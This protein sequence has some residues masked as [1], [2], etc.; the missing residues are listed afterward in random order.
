MSFLGGI[1]MQA[2]LGSGQ[3]QRCSASCR[4]VA[5]CWGIFLSADLINDPGLGIQ[6]EHVGH[7]GPRCLHTS[8]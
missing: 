3:V 2:G 8:L 7:G 4:G 5:V 6:A 1:E